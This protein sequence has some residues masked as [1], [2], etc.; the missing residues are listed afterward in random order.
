MP[1]DSKANQT[2]DYEDVINPCDTTPAS[3]GHRRP[4]WHR[5][6]TRYGN[7]S[8]VWRHE[9]E[10]EILIHPAADNRSEVLKKSA[11]SGTLRRV[12]LFDTSGEA[13]AFVE[14]LL[15]DLEAQ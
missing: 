2:L 5:D 8:A 12:R 11:A 4:G 10:D 15:T 13:E 14:G 1:D 9:T 6:D 3:V 7:C